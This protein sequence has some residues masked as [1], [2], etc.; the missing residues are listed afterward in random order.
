M[1]SAG[2]GAKEKVTDGLAAYVT[3]VN[4]RESIQLGAMVYKRVAPELESLIGAEDICKVASR[5]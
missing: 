1:P 3:A 2:E 5:P 4:D